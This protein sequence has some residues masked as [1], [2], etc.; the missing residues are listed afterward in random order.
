MKILI[1]LVM[2][3]SLAQIPTQVLALNFGL[4]ETK[5]AATKGG[6]AGGTTDTTLSE[7]VGLVIKIALSLVGVVFLALTVYAGFLWM[8]AR[9]E[10]EPIG[11]AKKIITA[12]IIGLLIVVAAYAITDYVLVR[13]F[14]AVS[15][16]ITK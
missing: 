2:L 16:Q 15:P 14:S 5:D 6:Y 8:T 1:Y 3:I 12:C 11:K 13:M 7:T 10:D 4:V 9:G